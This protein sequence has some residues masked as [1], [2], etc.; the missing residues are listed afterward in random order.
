LKTV[1]IKIQIFDNR[2]KFKMSKQREELEMRTKTIKDHNPQTFSSLKKR[3][4]SRSSLK[5]CFKNALVKK[6]FFNIKKINFFIIT[7]SERKIHLS[8]M[9]FHS[10]NS[11]VPHK[12]KFNEFVQFFNE[13]FLKNKEN[14]H[15]SVSP[16]L[17]KQK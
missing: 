9:A 5:I 1:K 8:S 10:V 14:F 16:S 3:T 17:T 7:K 6:Y 11:Y 13:N 4:K 2:K 15:F 12:S